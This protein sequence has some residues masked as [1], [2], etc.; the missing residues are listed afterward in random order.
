M[1]QPVF[2][3]LVIS[4]LFLIAGCAS[5]SNIIGAS[6]IAIRDIAVTVREECGAQSPD[7]CS[8]ESVISTEDR[9]IIKDQL[10]VALSFVDDAN[11]IR[12]GGNPVACDS[13]DECLNAS[14]G[15]LRSVESVL[16]ARGL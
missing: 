7:P 1:K 3:I 11:L 4:A 13:V 8:P 6:Y 2:Q 14:R 9:D 10:E 15:I 12:S 16:V 5:T